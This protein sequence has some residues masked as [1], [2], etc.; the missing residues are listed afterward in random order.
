MK[1]IFDLEHLKEAGNCHF[2]NI[3]CI[4]CPHCSCRLPAIYK[5]IECLADSM[6][7]RHGHRV[8]LSVLGFH[9]SGSTT[10]LGKLVTYWRTQ[11][12][13]HKWIDWR[14]V[15]DASVNL[16]GVLAPRPPSLQP[17]TIRPAYAPAFSLLSACLGLGVLLSASIHQSILIF[18]VNGLSRHWPRKCL[19]SEVVGPLQSSVSSILLSIPARSSIDVHSVSQWVRSCLSIAGKC[20]GIL[21]MPYLQAANVFHGHRNNPLCA[22]GYVPNVCQPNVPP[23]VDRTQ[24]HQQTQTRYSITK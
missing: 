16:P 5:A 2:L 17:H 15:A 4:C 12:P 6:S 1:T 11:H 23:K 13:V 18:Q 3:Q 21:F 20:T 19:Y 9:G 24:A 22:S 7:K 10:L 8:E 14:S